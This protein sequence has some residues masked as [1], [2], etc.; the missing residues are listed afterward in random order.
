MPQWVELPPNLVPCSQTNGKSIY[1]TDYS[2]KRPGFQIHFQRTARGARS[3]HHPRIPKDPSRSSMRASQTG[4]YVRFKEECDKN[5]A[6]KIGKS[7]CSVPKT[8]QSPDTKASEVYREVLSE[9]IQPSLNLVR[10][11][12][13]T[14]TSAVNRDRE[15]M[16]GLAGKKIEIIPRPPKAEESKKTRT[17]V[18]PGMMNWLSKSNE[19]EK[20]VVCNFMNHVA[21]A[22]TKHTHPVRPKTPQ[23]NKPKFPNEHFYK[24]R[25]KSAHSQRIMDRVDVPPRPK[26]VHTFRNEA[27]EVNQESLGLEENKEHDHTNHAHHSEGKCEL[28]DY[29]RVKELLEYLNRHDSQLGEATLRHLL[30]PRVNPS[31]GYPTNEDYDYIHENSFFSYTTAKDRGYFIIAPDWV[32]ER[33][34]IPLPKYRA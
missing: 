16:Y 3:F 23:P 29:M 1:T 5:L 13:K 10:Q 12:W 17:Q 4:S 19:Y 33:K 11:A 31:Y 20:A 2:S 30:R 28:C 7:V 8:P 27:K 14:E 6:A 22:T 21:K 26:T 9:F 34:G 18:L 32:S 24:Q 25:A 15:R